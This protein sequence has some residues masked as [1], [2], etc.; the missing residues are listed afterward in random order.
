MRRLTAPLARLTL[1]RRIGVVWGC[2]VFMAG[3]APAP[4]PYLSPR[5][6]WVYWNSPDERPYSLAVLWGDGIL[7]ANPLRPVVLDAE[8][9]VVALGPLVTDAYIHCRTPLTACIIARP[10]QNGDGSIAG[11]AS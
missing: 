10:S 7:A 9:H 6:D 2:L 1:W 5:A 8:G 3:P 4:S 11:A